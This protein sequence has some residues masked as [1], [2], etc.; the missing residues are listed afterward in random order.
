MDADD[1]HDTMVRIS[2]KNNN[3]DAFQTRIEELRQYKC[4]HGHTNVRWVENNLQTALRLLR[5]T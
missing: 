2:Q 1:I 5:P 3:K 4:I